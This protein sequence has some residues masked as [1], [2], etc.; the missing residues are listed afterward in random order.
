MK[1]I[2]IVLLAMSAVPALAAEDTYGMAGCGLGSIIFGDKGG[3]EQ[4]FAGT[5][6]SIYG[7]QTFGISSGT[8]NCVETSTGGKRAALFITANRESLEKEIARGDGESLSSLSE[9]MNCKGDSFNS[10]LQS[11]YKAIFPTSS[12]TTEQ[13]VDSIVK[14]GQNC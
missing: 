11:N 12:V 9:V 3:I 7:N 6:N 1:K 2:L 14:L 5:T 8:S 10:T 4:I 13:V